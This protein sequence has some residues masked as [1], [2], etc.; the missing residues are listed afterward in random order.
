MFFEMRDVFEKHHFMIESDVIEE[1][2]VLMQLP[3]IADVGHDRQAK[4]LGHQADG[5]KLADTSRAGCN[6]PGRNALLRSGESS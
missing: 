4:L 6:L 5:E 3:H 1:H 2:Q